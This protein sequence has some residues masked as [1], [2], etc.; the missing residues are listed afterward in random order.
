MFH[1]LKKKKLKSGEKIKIDNVTS[2]LK[3]AGSKIYEY[4]L[5]NIVEKV[6]KSLKKKD[7]KNFYLYYYCLSNLIDYK[8]SNVNPFVKMFVK[9]ILDTYID[10][11]N[12]K[13]NYLNVCSLL[14]NN[15]ILPGYNDMKLYD[16]Q[17]KLFTICKR[18]HPKLILYTAPTGTGKTMSPLGLSENNKVIFVCAARHVGLALAKSA[19]SIKKKIAFAFGCNGAEDIRLH[20]FAA[21]K[22]KK[23]QLVDDYRCVCGKLKCGK[24][25]QDIKFKNGNKKVDNSV[26]DK[27]EIMICDIKSYMYAMYYMCAF[28]SEEN[29]ILYWDEPTITMDYKDH[30]FHKDIKNNWSKNKIPNIILSSATLPKQDELVDV[31]NDFKT[32]FGLGVVYD[33]ISHDCNKSI[34]LLNKDN[35]VEMPHYL[36]NN[37]DEMICSVNHCENYKTLMRYYSLEEI[38]KFVSYV[39]D[40]GYIRDERYLIENYFDSVNDLQIDKIKIHYISVLKNLDSNK[41]LE[42]FDYFKTNRVKKYDSTIHISTSDAK[43][44][45]DGP[46]IFLADN[47]DKIAKFILTESKIHKKVMD[48]LTETINYNEKII[49]EIDKLEKKEEDMIGSAI[50][51]EN[52]MSDEERIPPEVKKIRK[53]IENLRGLVKSVSLHDIFIP[54]TLD[55]L[56]HWSDI[57][58]KTNQFSCKID[59]NMVQKIML[60]KIEPMWKILLLMGVGVF[61]THKDI[62]YTEI[63][64]DLADKQHLYLIVASSDYIYGTNYQF[65]HG[66]LSKDLENMT[67]EKIIQSLGRIGRNNNQKSYSIRL[68][69]DDLIKKIMNKEEDKPEVENMNKLFITEFDE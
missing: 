45:T 50:E 7:L 54:N 19:I 23:H 62:T 8:V 34:P 41:Y 61:T 56:K 28:N 37:Y 9:F 69:N 6:L 24:I 64:K 33:I 27:V 17:K 16:H 60:L 40:H 49:A 68:R 32:K 58:E 44:L 36:H 59:E 51:N 3:K 25:G 13:K 1:Y 21:S 48:D 5:I 39:C 52:K 20:Y 18:D 30:E 35:Y 15:T 38:V 43:T 46:T 4:Y 65:M 26:G 63:M 55:H 31:V 11:I 29:L 14:E 2:E 12:I 53:D 57:I 22:F 10:S 67:Q 47:V 42:I 66:Y